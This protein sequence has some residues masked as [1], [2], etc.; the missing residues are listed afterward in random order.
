[1]LKRKRR[2]TLRRVARD[3]QGWTRTRQI[4]CRIRLASPNL[5]SRNSTTCAVRRESPTSTANNQHSAAFLG[6]TSGTLSSL[7]SVLSPFQSNPLPSIVSIVPYS[8]HF[9]QILSLAS[10]S[11]ILT[12]AWRRT[13]YTFFFIR[14]CYLEMSLSVLKISLI[15]ASKRS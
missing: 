3:V 14:T 15:L 2:S 11:L 10:L 8:L 5:C 13:E 7:Y 4:A 6:A 1:M 9:L 12:H